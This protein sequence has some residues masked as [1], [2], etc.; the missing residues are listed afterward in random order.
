M[1]FHY[2]PIEDPTIFNQ[3]IITKKKIKKLFFKRV[4][5]SNPPKFKLIK[6]I[7]MNLKIN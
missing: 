5:L 7:N 2:S 6:R 1:L 3:R 4:I